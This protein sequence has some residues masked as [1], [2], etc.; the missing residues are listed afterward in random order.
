MTCEPQEFPLEEI[1]EHNVRLFASNVEQKQITL[2][3]LVSKGTIAYA[4]YTMVDTIIR[5]LLSNALK[6]TDTGGT[7]EVSAHQPTEDVVE[8]AVSDTGTGMSQQCIDNLFQ[9]DA[10]STRTGTA[11][12]EGTGLGLIL[13]K[14]LVEKNGGTIRVAS[15]VGKG[16]AFTFSLPPYKKE[17]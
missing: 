9:I 1:A 11:G 14:E 6:F 16:T 8:I 7:I 15:E 10:K 5:N 3:N 4:D 17:L 13:C 12:E 2:R